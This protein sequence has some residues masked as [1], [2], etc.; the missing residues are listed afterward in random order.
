MGLQIVERTAALEELLII[1]LIP[2]SLPGRNRQDELLKENNRA[3]IALIHKWQPVNI[4]FIFM[5]T[6]DFDYIGSL[7]T[8]RPAF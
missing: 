6:T 1:L 3:A 2:I 4:S 7:D 8:A 5:K